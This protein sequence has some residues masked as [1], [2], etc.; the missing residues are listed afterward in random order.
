[1][2]GGSAARFTAVPPL[3]T[4][5]VIAGAG[6][7]LPRGT[8]EDHWTRCGDYEVFSSGIG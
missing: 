2:Q 7:A 4:V 1:M 8:T 3:G 5:G 6:T